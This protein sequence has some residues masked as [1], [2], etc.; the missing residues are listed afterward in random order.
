M[1]KIKNTP[2]WFNVTQSGPM[3]GSSCHNN[4]LLTSAHYSFGWFFW[5]SAWIRLLRIFWKH[6]KFHT[7]LLS[8]SA[9]NRTTDKDMWISFVLKDDAVLVVLMSISSSHDL[10][11]PQEPIQNLVKHVHVVNVTQ[12]ML[13]GETQDMGIIKLITKQSW[14]HII[15]SVDN[16]VTS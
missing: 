8:F 15:Q 9:G 4:V 1:L 12:V 3:D 6:I 16:P 10:P 11:I 13:P 14:T 5:T 2:Q 7:C